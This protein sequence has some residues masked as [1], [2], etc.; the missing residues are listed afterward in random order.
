MFINDKILGRVSTIVAMLILA[1]LLLPILILFINAF[2][3]SRFFEFPPTGFTLEWFVEFA[4]SV[5]YQTSLRVSALLAASAVGIAL[6]AGIPAAYAI[7]RYK[8]PGRN[9]LQGLFL[10]PLLLPSIIWAL[11]LVQYFAFL[12][13][14]GSFQGL[15]LAHSI[16][17]IPYVIRLVL[18]SFSFVDRDLENAAKSLGAPPFRTFFEITLPLVAPGIIVSAVFGFMISFTDVVIATFVSGA[19]YITFPVRIYSQLRSEGLDPL[20][21]AISA[22]VMAVIVIIALIGEKLIHWSRFV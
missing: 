10:S 22:V 3:A 19:R 1:F 4:K 18:A 20:S 5:E 8:F 2:N 7:D 9:F 13:V 16:I 11:G 14:L 6:V 21:V 15:I 12:R 17:I